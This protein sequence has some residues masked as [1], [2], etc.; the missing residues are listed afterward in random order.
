MKCLVL[1]ARAA[2][3]LI[4]TLVIWFVSA[5]LSFSDLPPIGGGP[6]AVWVPTCGTF[7]VIFF[8]LP[9]LARIGNL[10][11]KPASPCAR[12]TFL[13]VLLIFLALIAVIIVVPNILFAEHFARMNFRK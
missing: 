12:E 1:A 11:R 10:N 2:T 4:P 8:G 9:V 13:M 6:A 7:L 5:V 3:A